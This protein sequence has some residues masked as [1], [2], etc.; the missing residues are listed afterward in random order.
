MAVFFSCTCLRPLCET[1]KGGKTLHLLHAL[2]PAQ[3]QAPQ[4]WPAQQNRIRSQRQ[5]L[6]QPGRCKSISAMLYLAC[7]M[8]TVES[9]RTTVAPK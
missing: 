3:G 2:L 8:R 6:Q 9:L 7:Q 1:L 4:H 5:R